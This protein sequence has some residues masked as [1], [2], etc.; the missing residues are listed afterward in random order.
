MK[1]QNPKIRRQTR[2][3]AKLRFIKDKP[4]ISVYR[5]NK[6]FYA[7]VIDPVKGDIITSSSSFEIRKSAKDKI[8]K[9][10][11]AKAVGL[12]LAKKL[13]KKSITK[14]VFDRGSYA[15]LG[16]VQ[17]FAQGLREGGIKI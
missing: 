8:K 10:E 9:T 16:R 12:E 17:A 4:R 3:R 5:S 1:K 11:E 6:Y 2:V 14:G 7:Q 15:Y 13:K